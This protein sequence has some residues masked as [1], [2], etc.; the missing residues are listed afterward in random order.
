M[1]YC[2]VKYVTARSEAGSIWKWRILNASKA[3]IL[4][5]GEADSQET[6]V[7]HAHEAIGEAVRAH[8]PHQV[9]ESLQHL[10]DKALHIL[11]GARSITPMEAIKALQPFVLA[12]RAQSF[13]DDR[14]A[15]ASSKAVD[16]LVKSLAA[17]RAATDDVWES[18]IETTL[19]F[20]NGLSQPR[21]R[22]HQ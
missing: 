6:A 9:D 12:M 18:A 5:S 15:E 20:A 1:Q 17:R 14:L 4:I 11:H 22:S 10:A 3:S 16:H 7:R 13:K 8:G 2:G 21:E 19:S